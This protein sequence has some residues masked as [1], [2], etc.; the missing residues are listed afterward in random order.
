MIG[1]EKLSEIRASLLERCGT[2]GEDMI[3]S[4]DE[5][6]RKLE[7]QQPPNR[8]EIETLK[9]IRDGLRV[10]PKAAKGTR[11]RARTR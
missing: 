11:K 2:S 5:R 9:L 1:K 6:V 3:K 8:V 7:R 10:K 4:L